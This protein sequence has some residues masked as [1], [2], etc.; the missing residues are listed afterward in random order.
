MLAESF[1]VLVEVQDV[2]ADMLSSGRYC[3]VGEGKAVGAVG[4][5]SCEVAHHRQHRTLHA[6][7]HRN[8]AQPLQGLLYRGDPVGSRAS[9]INS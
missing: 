2:D 5:A 4:A 6:A 3:Q 9:T 8:L 7:I 1:E